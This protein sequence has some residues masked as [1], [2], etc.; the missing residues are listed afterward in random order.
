MIPRK[1]FPNMPDEVFEMWLEPIAED[2][3]WPF[4]D[5]SDSIKGTKWSG[6][7]GN[8]DLNFWTTIEWSRIEIEIY[9]ELFTD[10]T[11]RHLIAII[12]CC[13]E[14]AFT[15]TANLLDTKDRFRA[16]AE[17]I[18]TNGTIPKPIVAVVRSRK[19][20]IVDGNHR[21]AALLHVGVTPGYKVPMWVPI[22]PRYNKADAPAKNRR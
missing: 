6:I 13:V 22:P 19:V 5:S 16:C 21:I 2:Y 4:Q 8:Y 11:C 12:D 15:I 3:G 20:E 18:S 17:F 9:P 7:F 14:S 10:I 1:F